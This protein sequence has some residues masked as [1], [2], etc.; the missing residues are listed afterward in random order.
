M[1]SS[2]RPTTYIIPVTI[3]VLGTMTVAS[4]QSASPFA[5]KSTTQAWEDFPQNPAQAPTIAP[6]PLPPSPLAPRSSGA[7]PI[8]TGPI[9]TGAGLPQLPQVNP[10][11][12]A[13]RVSA[14]P[15][16]N[17]APSAASSD[18]NSAA[19][20]WKL[21]KKS[22]HNLSLKKPAQ[23]TSG[24]YYPGRRNGGQIQTSPTHN[25]GDYERARGAQS[26]AQPSNPYP[27]GQGSYPARRPNVA[28]HNDANTAASPQGYRA[29]DYGQAAYGQPS[30]LQYGNPN[31]GSSETGGPN[32]D[33]QQYAQNGYPQSQIPQSQIP[34]SQVSTR[35][36]QPV[37][38][39]SSPNRSWKD[40]LGFGKLR[41]LFTGGAT[42]GAAAVNNP[43]AQGGW[44]VE[45]IGDADAGVE[46]SAITQGGLEYGVN[47]RARA[48]YDRFRR[49]FGQR[50]ADCPPTAAGCSSA[51]IDGTA[52][53]L[54]GHTSQ[55]FTDG[56]DDARAEEI[57]L[58]SAYV[59]LRS[60][61]GDVTLG[62]DDGAAYLFSLGAPSLLK[63]GASNSPV[64]YTGLDSVKTVNDA[65]G[66]AEKVTYIT[67]RLLGDTVGVGVQLGVSYAP[68]ARGCGVDFCVRTNEDQGSGTIAADLQDVIEVGLALDRKFGNGLEVEATVNY[69][70][71][72]E[73]SGFAGLDD[74]ESFNGGL[75]LKYNEWVLGGSYLNSNNGLLDGDY[76]AY[77]IGLTWKP[78]RFGFTLGYGHAT[79]DNV[80]LISD[81]A[82]FGLSYDFDK[83]T[84]G[85]GVQYIDR[86]TDVF[87][88]IDVTRQSE[89]A[90]GIFIETGFT[91]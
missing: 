63:V 42:V 60:A 77:D 29:P 56:A 49:G 52:T 2:F 17:R 65:S 72:D 82:I 89:D 13:G 5:K 76:E 21:G 41:T 18:V 20:N 1:S 45:F 35:R 15:A 75:E 4:A 88:G 31:Y 19:D 3:A 27:Q 33:Q 85:T 62:R 38:G 61:Y 54:R 24:I 23:Q 53:G 91:F 69:A 90:Y 83:I 8:S 51:V 39:Q 81:Q 11:P 10:Q 25:I 73:R 78:S 50:L 34:Q 12:I 80:N 36:V 70:R 28:Y 67:P 37:S 44:D 68:N 40:R 22:A 46:V 86:S 47:L 74:L 84:I 14:I 87:N 59:F 58:E 32:Y 30:E 66:F 43:N 16:S 7:S 26:S 64:D 71:A 55:F 48:Q 6:S 79:D 57:Q 9:S